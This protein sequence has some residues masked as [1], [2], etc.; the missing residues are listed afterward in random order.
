MLRDGVTS[1]E[2]MRGEVVLLAQVSAW[3]WSA[4][5]MT[6][7]F[8]TWARLRRAFVHLPVAELLSLCVLKEIVAKEKEHPAEALSG[9]PALRVRESRPGFSAGLLSGRK[10]IALPGDARCA[11]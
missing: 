1:P 8:G 4:A 2:V 11:A 7:R 6:F 9:P 10:G 5:A 3:F